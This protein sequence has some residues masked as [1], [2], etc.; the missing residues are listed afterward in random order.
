MLQV[1]ND[2]KLTISNMSLNNHIPLLA[3]STD[4]KEIMKLDDEGNLHIS[5]LQGSLVMSDNTGKKW[6]VTINSKGKFIS[7]PFEKEQRIKHRI[8]KLLKKNASK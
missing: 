3:F 5:S 8:N 2:A 4:N 1:R 7:E 6:K